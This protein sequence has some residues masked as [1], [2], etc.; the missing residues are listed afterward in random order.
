MMWLASATS[1]VLGDADMMNGWGWV[2]MSLAFLMMVSVIALVAWLIWRWPYQTARQHRLPRAEEIL[3]E[4]FA[5]G[6][7][8]R[9]EYDEVRSV[10]EER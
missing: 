8:S 4:R 3:A 10:L 2:G 9:D 7:I 5:R 6:E 1:G